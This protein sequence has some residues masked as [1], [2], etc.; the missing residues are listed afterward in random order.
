MKDFLGRNLCIGNEI[1][2]MSVG[3]RYLR[4]GKIIK[5][6]KAKLTIKPESG[7]ENTYQFPN[8]VIKIHEVDGYN[9]NEGT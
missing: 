8:Q 5:I 3:Y 7:V 9:I 6:G 4:K 2:F 1:V